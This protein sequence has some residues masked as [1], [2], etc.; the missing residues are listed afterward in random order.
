[1]TTRERRIAE[2]AEECRA[3]QLSRR[4]FG[5]RLLAVTGSVSAALAAMHHFGISAEAHEIAAPAKKAAPAKER[6]VEDL[7]CSFC[8]KSSH[9]VSKLI[10]G[11][12]V[13]ICDECVAV[14]NDIIEEDNRF[15]AER[16]LN[17]G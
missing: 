1:M 9:D 7:R 14:C 6:D 8:N 2:W 13:F 4:D 16:G 15:G 3:G 5:Q 10:A 12:T 17:H 11:P